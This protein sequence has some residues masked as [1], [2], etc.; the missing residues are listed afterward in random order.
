LCY[1]ARDI[2]LSSR[3]RNGRA[4]ILTNDEGSGPVMHDGKRHG[5]LETVEPK[6]EVRYSAMGLMSRVAFCVSLSL[7]F[8]LLRRI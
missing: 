7:F 4:E 8:G 6:L 2:E 5:V 3:A 1:P